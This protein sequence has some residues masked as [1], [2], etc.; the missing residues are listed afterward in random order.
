MNCRRLKPR[1]TPSTLHSVCVI[2]V[3][4]SI[5]GPVHQPAVAEPGTKQLRANRVI[6][7]P[8]VDGRLD[9]TA[10]NN[11]VFV[12]DFVQKQPDFGAAPSRRTEIA[13]VYDS[14]A[15]YV[16]ARMFV[17]GPA[18]MQAVMTRRDE[19]GSAERIIVSLDTFLDRRTAY[20]FAVT[21]AGVRADWYHN[22]DAEFSRDHSFNPVWRAKITVARDHWSAEMRIPF[23]QLRFPGGARQRWGI[24][25]NRYIPQRNEDIFWIPV[26]REKTAWSSYFGDLNGLDGIR[27]PIRIEFL[28]Y[29]S[30]DVTL[31]SEEIVADGADDVVSDVRVGG[32]LTMGLGPN[33]T[34]NATVLPDFGQVEADPAE[35]N[36][37]AFETFFDER[38]PFFTEGS[39]LLQGSG[40]SFFYS[41]RIGERPR[42]CSRFSDLSCPNSTP[43]LSAAKITGQLPSRLSL[44][45]LAAVTGETDATWISTG[46]SVLVS[47][48]SA[49]GTARVQQEFGANGS[50]VGASLAG[51]VRDLD[52]SEPIAQEIARQSLGGGVDWRLR[53]DGG[54]YEFSGSLGFTHVRGEPSAIEALARNQVH[55]FQRPDQEHVSLDGTRTTMSG[56]AGGLG[57]EKRHGNWRWEVET[58]FESPDFDPNEVGRLRSADDIALF[59]ELSYRQT[60]PSD[61][62]QSWNLGVGSAYE[63]NFGLVRDP[64]YQF[65]FGAI[66]L[67][68]F[69]NLQSNLSIISPGQNDFATR[70]GPL[71]GVGWGSE[72]NMS[73]SSPFAGRYRWSGSFSHVSQETGTAG[74]QLSSSLILQPLDRLFI[75]LSPRYWQSTDNRQY[76]DTIDTSYIFGT[77]EH[78]ELSFQTR[79]RVAI[80]PDLT[81]DGYLEPFAASGRYLS[82]GELA[83]PGSR[84]LIDWSSTS[85]PDFTSLSLRSTAVLRW[86]FLPGSMLFLVWQQNRS[87]Y[88]EMRESVLSGLGDTFGVPGGS[89][90]ALKISYW[91]SVDRLRSSLTR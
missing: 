47:P 69:W 68:N 43:I 64:G 24:N 45:V 35:V 72:F 2:A 91:L 5:I 54:A 38:R 52:L 77:V 42:V 83:E 59:G 8:D 70:G 27:Q 40:N 37:S 49:Y 26:P 29:I 6:Q 39:Q 63:W 81:L 67:K 58:G 32:D 1:W 30:G 89:T 62:L 18:D 61:W 9:D 12:S 14:D 66:E 19:T 13:V 3:A 53:F 28:P 51:V 60:I 85:V 46:E 82:Y 84:D 15:L 87:D 79:V 41:R 44:G 17:N 90:L 65:V 75:S 76:V 56:L 34:L 73:V 22:D 4:C 21:S 36:L 78:R 31:R 23:T 74:W 50:L 55:Y 10:W 11:A 25:F 48:L 88:R 16:A 33:V 71:M 20:S 57:L 80:S 86:E 7:A